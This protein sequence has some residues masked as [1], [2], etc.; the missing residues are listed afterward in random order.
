MAKISFDKLIRRASKYFKFSFKLNKKTSSAGNPSPKTFTDANKNTQLKLD[1]ERS[2]KNITLLTAQSKRLEAALF[3]SNKYN[4]ELSKRTEQLKSSL[5]KSRSN[6]NKLN[7][8]TINLKS[9]LSQAR[10]ALREIKE[11]RVRSVSSWGQSLK[12]LEPPIIKL[13]DEE[14][15]APPESS[16]SQILPQFSAKK[17]I[18]ADQPWCV[19]GVRDPFFLLDENG[20]LAKHEG[21]FILFFSGR[22]KSLLNGGKTAIG[23]ARSSNL[24]D[25]KIDPYPVFK[26]GSYATS[27]SAIKSPN[28]SIKLFYAFDT[29]RGFRSAESW[30]LKS[31]TISHDII[32]KPSQFFCRRIGLPYV[33]KKSGAWYLLFEGLRKHFSIYG[34][35][36]KDGVYW[37]P[38]HNGEPI[39]APSS[40]GW[41]ELAQANPSVTTISGELFLVYNGYRTAGEWDI[42]I[43][44][45]PDPAKKIMHTSEMPLL[46]RSDLLGVQTSRLEGCRIFSNIMNDQDN[47]FFFDLPTPDSFEAGRIWQVTID[48]IVANGAYKLAKN[49]IKNKNLNKLQDPVYDIRETVETLKSDETIKSARNLQ[50][51][52]EFNDKFSEVYFDIWD[53]QPIQR[54]T[55]VVEEH[56][57]KETVQSGD[58]VLLVGS[59]GGREIECLLGLDAN[60]TAMDISPKMLEVGAKRYPKENIEWVHADAQ[61]PPKNLKD[62]DHVLALGLVLCYLPNP[63]LAL[64]NL[65]DTLKVGR[66]LTLGIVNGEHFTEADTRKYLNSGRVR[67]AYTVKEIK[68]MLQRAGYLTTNVRG[69][70]FFID[71]L[72]VHWNNNPD[73]LKPNQSLLIEKFAQLEIDFANQI[74]AELAKHLWVTA[75]AI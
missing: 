56:W 29:A 38:M 3:K 28:G 58:K 8:R 66:S 9:S 7:E 10:Q 59:G 44:K 57:I 67:N 15:L 43:Q 65:R 33:F 16:I 39:Y 47:L 5:L 12:S 62:F 63:E 30:D 20:L 46:S 71:G 40:G 35:Q 17:I 37:T 51:E 2:N 27:G 31:W 24:I 1:L 60:I 49:K 61:R 4:K 48:H 54:I 72:P 14:K 50:A 70:R 6:I 45:F 21:S 73:M 52:E 23:L 36:S 64:A 32:A 13:S 74:E 53:R 69:S 22:D 18:S 41:D 26:D 68:G 75:R 55:K 11:N 34:L 25:W 19:F 42:G